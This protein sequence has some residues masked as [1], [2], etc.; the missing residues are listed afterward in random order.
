MPDLLMI[1]E[2]MTIYIDMIAFYLQ[3]AGGIT[4]VWKELIIRMLRDRYHVILILQ[5]AACD[6]LYF[7]QIMQ[8]KPKIVYEQGQSVRINRYM[9]V[10]CHFEEGSSFISTYY[11]VPEKSTLKQ[12]VVV[13]DFTYEYY[14]KGI[15]KAVHA[16]QKKKAVQHATVV[17]CVSENTKKDLKKFYPWAKNK[18]IHVIYNGIN[19]TY[20]H[21]ETVGEIKLLGKYNKEPYFMFVGSRAVYKRF[22]F[23]I[24][25]AAQ[26]EYGLLIIGGGK[27]TES[28][29]TELENRLG[30]NYL[31]LL[32]VED[33]E[34]NQIYNKA[35]ALIYP[36][37]YE[38]FG[39]PVIE[40]Q[41]T[42]CPVIAREGSSISE[43]VKNKEL[44]MKECTL[45]EA[46]RVLKIFHDKE[47]ILE[48][49]YKNA[50]RFS[51]EKTYQEYRKRL[52][53]EQNSKVKES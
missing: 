22:D 2:K 27:L 40:A 25:V 21:L 53:E 20:R 49:G 3:K 35:F 32:G 30:N 17:I 51:W 46:E 38:G 1:G 47:E 8:R 13:H 11:R 6:N 39:I 45:E 4:V 36:S 48:E 5:N 14:V 29:I 33:E 42:G 23:A 50:E 26:C 24:A 10:R 52:N 19:E 44:L 41:K 12:Y 31:Q 7:E 28:E 9:P 15:K 18:E 37:E 34:L 16:W 43:I